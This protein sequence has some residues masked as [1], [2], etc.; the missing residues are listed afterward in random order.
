MLVSCRAPTP[1]QPCSSWRSCSTTPNSCS[2]FFLWRRAATRSCSS[3]SSCSRTSATSG[4][5]GTLDRGDCRETE[6]FDSICFY[7]LSLCAFI[8]H[9]Q[10]LSV[11]T[12]DNSVCASYKWYL[13]FKCDTSKVKMMCMIIILANLNV[14]R[15]H[16]LREVSQNMNDPSGDRNSTTPSCGFGWKCIFNEIVASLSAQQG[17]RLLWE[18]ELRLL[19]G[20]WLSPPPS[21]PAGLSSSWLLSCLPPSAPASDAAPAAVV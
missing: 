19:V 10:L 5:A 1:L 3:S 13:D 20:V 7:C 6:I 21:P 15:A 9:L 8:I 18:A 2:S 4:C 14:I 11:N 16:L 17:H 12:L